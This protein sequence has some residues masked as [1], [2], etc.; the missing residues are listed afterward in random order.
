MSPISG[1]N[2]PKVAIVGTFMCTFDAI[3]I[4]APDVKPDTKLYH[5]FLFN[6]KEKMASFADVKV[7][8]I[9]GDEKEA[10]E[11]SSRLL[12]DNVDIIV[13]VPVAYTL[14]ITTTTLLQNQKAPIIIFSTEILDTLPGNLDFGMAMMYGNVSCIPD[15]TNG[16]IKSNIKF[17]FMM[18][19]IDEK[20]II[21]ELKNIILA[22]KAIAKLKASSI[23]L[24]GHEYPGMCDLHVDIKKLEKEFGINFLNIDYDEIYDAFD[25]VQK[26][27]VE[28]LKLNLKKYN[29][30]KIENGPLERSLKLVKVFQNISEKYQLDSL[31]QLCSPI[32]SNK[33][34]GVV[35][36]YGLAVLNEKGV[37]VT[38]EYDIGTAIILII[39]RAITG[40]AFFTEYYVNDV[41][42]NYILCAHCGFGNLSF[43]EDKKKV[44]IVSNPCFPGVM[45]DGIS[46]EFALPKGIY[47]MADFVMNN[48]K[49]IIHASEVEVVDDK[50]FPMGVPQMKL[51]FK[52]QDKR[53]AFKKWVELGGVHHFAVTKENIT[54]ILQKV[55]DMLGIEFYLV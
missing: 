23:G 9:V 3:L 38:C 34:I 17:N 52:N 15:V 43:I 16:L 55:A 29:L 50:P 10:Q 49:I 26:A 39:L 2:N 19:Q 42:K 30:G 37:N 51:R 36:C 27:E 18:G 5:N 54:G 13:V 40:D 53:V 46:L 7:Y 6:I 12:K 22:A 1:N 44:N 11:M 28:K 32:I 21:K 24:L 41:K 14:D 25:K 8:G 20:E 35:P 45:G 4:D 31:A 48:N 33:R 47:T